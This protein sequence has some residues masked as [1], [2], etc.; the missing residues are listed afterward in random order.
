LKAG[1]YRS[2]A[3]QFGLKKLHPNSHLYTSDK[4]IANFPGRGFQINASFGFGKKEL[5]DAIGNEQRANITIRNFPGSVA[6]LRKR[7]KLSE[8]GACYLFATTLNNGQ[9]IILKTTKV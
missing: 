5:K 6:D 4:W 3:E 1:G 9:K 2:I 7:L 8:G